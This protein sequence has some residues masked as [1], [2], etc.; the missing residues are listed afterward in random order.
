MNAAPTAWHENEGPLTRA[1]VGEAVRLLEAQGP[2]ED[3][4][5]MRQA[6]ALGAAGA[7]HA[8]QIAERAALLGRRLGLQQRLTQARQA[9]PWLLLLITAGVVLGGALLA[10]AVVDAQERRINVLA[11]LAALLGLHGLTFAL[12]LLGLLW[13]GRAGADAAH[14]AAAGAG[15]TLIGRLWLALGTRLALGRGAEGAAL[16]QA[17]LQLL[18]RAR[19]LPWVAG[20]ASHAVWALSLGAA[21]GA[22]LFALALRRYTLGWETTLLH[23][24]TLAQ[25][26]QWL[27]LL[28]GWLGLPAPDAAALLAEP[29]SAAAL[30]PARDRLLAWWLIGCVAVYGLLPR[31]LALLAC[32]L[33]WRARRA[34]IAPALEQPYYRQLIA[35]LDALAPATVVD[36]DTARHDREPARA[37]LSGGTWPVL[38]VI[39]FELP[40]EQPWPPAPMPDSA[41]LVERIAGSAAEREQLLRRLAGL[42]PRWLV[43]ACAAAAS[44][45]RGT[46]RFLRELLALAGECRLWLASPA[47]LPHVE[48]ADG[49]ARWQRWLADVGLDTLRADRDWA[50]LVDDL[51]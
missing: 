30:A 43:L 41:V 11:A 26:V 22:L 25:A 1:W 29:G 6:A 18:A 39:G 47:A 38:A 45:D 40:P 13:A 36:A 7:G 35:R 21:V 14:S 17:A 3:S 15:G 24:Q 4:Q 51:K 23:P 33:V 8:A 9:A 46:E 31:L 32:V 34:R 16:A 49:S 20:L 27:G 48:S 2:L 19:L 42:R 5:P 44:P 37:S 10:G 28:P 12:W 50:A